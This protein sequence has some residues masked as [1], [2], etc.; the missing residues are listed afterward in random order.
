MLKELARQLTPPIAWSGLRS[1][2]SALFPDPPPNQGEPQLFDGRG[3]LFIEAAEGIRDYYE[4]GVGASTIWIDGHTDARI[5]SV[6]TSKEWIDKVSASLPYGKHSLTA[7]DVGPLGDWGMPLDFS[8]RKNFQDYVEGPWKQGEDAELV[9][10]D[11]RF[12]ISCFLNTLLRGNAGTNIIFD[13]Y[14]E[15]PTYHVV[16]EFIEP[17]RKSARQALF[18]IPE[19]L[20]KTSILSARDQFI[21]V[22][23]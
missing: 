12:R 8:A 6:D 13:D 18:I 4:Y 17:A 5:V 10:I 11:G 16:E 15:R 7:I 20:D 2:K 21:M 9:L 22:R 23:E 19:R 3:E 14:W 1:M